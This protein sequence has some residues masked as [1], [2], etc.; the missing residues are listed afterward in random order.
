MD[1]EAFKFWFDRDP[2]FSGV[3]IVIVGFVLFYV[4]VRVF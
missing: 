3:V 1:L 4:L 2:V